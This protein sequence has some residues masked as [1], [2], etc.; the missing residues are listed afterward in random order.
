MACELD[1]L[2]SLDPRFADRPACSGP[3]RSPVAER[4]A[5]GPAACLVRRSAARAAAAAGRRRPACPTADSRPPGPAAEPRVDAGESGRVKD[6]MV[7]VRVLGGRG[8]SGEWGVGKG[9]DHHVEEK[10]VTR[11]VSYLSAV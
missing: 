2:S 10:V 4:A 7:H 3:Q 8:R 9:T 5:S 11:N 1:A 6:G